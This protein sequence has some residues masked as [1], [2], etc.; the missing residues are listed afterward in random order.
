MGSPRSKLAGASFAAVA[1]LAVLSGCATADV[2]PAEP[3]TPSVEPTTPPIEPPVNPD[4]DVLFTITANVRAADNRTIGISMSAHTPVASTDGSV[5][6]LRDKFLDVCGEGTGA[7]PMTEQYLEENG[8]SLM[9]IAIT[10]ATPGL[11]FAAPIELFFGSPYFAQ[12]AIGDGVNPNPAGHTC[13]YGF[14]WPRSGDVLGIADFE[15]SEAT[16]DPT[17]WIFGRYGF[18]V[19][20]NSGATIETC[21]VTM[22]ELGLQTD[23]TDI[24]GWDPSS[25][26]DGLSCMIGYV[27]E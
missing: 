14:S 26:G 19:H 10:S 23:L 4:A 8:S 7:Q 20:P 22:T 15:N 18:S 12:A 13:F 16:P 6:E 2:T 11:T 1:L 17:Q 27:G 9:K 5:S 25:A 3:S 21:K 24:P